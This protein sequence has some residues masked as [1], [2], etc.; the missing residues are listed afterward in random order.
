MKQYTSTE[1][2]T[3][4]KNAHHGTEGKIACSI[5][6]DKITYAE[7]EQRSDIIAR[8]I[9]HRLTSLGVTDLSS[10]IRIGVNMS[11][12]INL[13]PAIYAIVKTGCCYVPIDATVPQERRNFI[14]SDASISLTLT[15]ELI[16]EFLAMGDVDCEIRRFNQP[17]AYIIYTSGTTG[18]PKG[19]P[20]SYSSLYHLMMHL[21]DEDNIRL[22]KD[23]VLL[24]FASINFDA[25]IKDIF[26]TLFYGAT[27]VIAEDRDKESARNIVSLL[28]NKNITYASIPPSILALMETFDF[29][30][31]RTLVSGGESMHVN[32]AEKIIGKKPYRFINAYGPT[33]CTVMCTLN[34][35]RNPDD[36]KNIGKPLPGVVAYVID[37]DGNAVA[38]DCEGELVVGGIQLT[39]G[40]INRPEL[41][42]KMFFKNPFADTIDEAP[43]LYHTG[44][45][46]RKKQDGS[47]IFVGRK[48]KQ[49][50][51][52]GFRIEVDDI[53]SQILNCK[54]VAAAHVRVE[55]SFGDKMLVAYV[56]LENN[57]VNID[58]IKQHLNVELPYYM[59][60][61]FWNVIDRL[62]LT[63]NGKIDDSRLTNTVLQDKMTN[64]T[65]LTEEEEHIMQVIAS[66]LNIKSLN[67]DLDLIDEIGLS[68]IQ[69]MRIQ[70]EL[71]RSAVGISVAGIYKYRTIRTIA[72]HS[73]KEAAYWY[74]A[75]SSTTKPVIVIVSGFTDFSYM[76]TKIVERLTKD[77]AIYVIESY[78]NILSNVDELSSDTL[79]NI[80][81]DMLKEVKAKHHIACIAGICNGGDQAL[82]LAHRMFADS[83]YKPLVVNMDGEIDRDAD[84]EKNASIDFP[85]FSEEVNKRR[86]NLDLSLYASYPKFHYDG[87]LGVFLCRDFF[88]Y[89]TPLDPN[90]TPKKDYWM[91]RFF[92]TNAERWLRT[93]PELA[94]TTLPA[95]HTDFWL[96]EPSLSM[97]SDYI[98]ANTKMA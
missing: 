67:I 7:L 73:L 31:L 4:I 34:E 26:G 32:V 29:T 9:L 53:T 82:L 89:W 5:A 47:F 76:Y 69:L 59:H 44:D 10:T 61:S 71:E 94:I 78:H 37:N 46:V 65:D 39:Q 96:T 87:P 23:S 18:Q 6:D 49:V 13:L 45:L 84:P 98:K 16:G 66:V 11:R 51:I 21:S 52:H 90:M 41:N 27:L 74:N 38:D 3:V 97:I 79:I 93:Y 15:D 12:T 64:D 58:T 95:S 92:D 1:L 24:L 50:K 40:Y 54:G 14:L 68:S 72:Q 35:L 42:E 63:T 22:D 80:Y 57:D 85:F 55:E 17:E 88:D 91:R 36:Y 20:I 25:S 30:S 43:V 19:V 33:E 81:I 48:D 75:D 60:P 2:L 62:P 86:N 83:E 8:H 77:Y 28:N 70:Y 56:V